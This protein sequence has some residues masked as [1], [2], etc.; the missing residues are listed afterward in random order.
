MNLNKLINFNILTAGFDAPKTNVAIIARPTNSLVQYSQMVG[1]AM[2]GKRSNG[3]DECRI[4]TV[5]DDIDEFR[6]VA[7]AFAHWDQLWVGFD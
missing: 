3:N 1:R 5:A 7:A 2:R 6:N 4:Y